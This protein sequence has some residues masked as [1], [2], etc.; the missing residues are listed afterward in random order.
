MGQ[1]TWLVASLAVSLL[2]LGHCVAL[3][4]A[5]PQRMHVECLPFF[6]SLLLHHFSKFA[7]HTSFLSLTFLLCFC[8]LTSH[9][10]LISVGFY[11]FFLT[12]PLNYLILIVLFF[13]LL[14]VLHLFFFLCSLPPSPSLRPVGGGVAAGHH[15]WEHQAGA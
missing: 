7:L 5:F 8:A 10:V 15:Q 2:A 11:L 1:A 4:G 14:S 13:Y 9:A 12:S 3:T 6:L